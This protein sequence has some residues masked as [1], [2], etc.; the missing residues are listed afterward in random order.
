MKRRNNTLLHSND[1]WCSRSFLWTVLAFAVACMSAATV[2][3]QPVVHRVADL[4]PGTN[5]SFPSNLTVFGSALFL[6]AYTTNT[7]RELWKYDGGGI[8]LVSNINDTVKDI[9]F[10][11][12][13]GNDSVPTGLKE[14]SGKLYFSAFD[15]RRGGE[16]WRTDGTNAVRVADINP[17]ANDTIKTNPASSWP[18]E[19]TAAGSKLYFSADS[20]G[21]FS[22][23]ELWAYDGTS[24]AR[25]A[26]IH[27]DFGAIYS[28]FPQGLKEFNGALYFMAD[29][30]TNGYEL[31]KQS[32]SGSVLLT[33]INPGGVTSSSF[34]KS[35]TAFNNALYFVATSS[36]A[37][38]ELWKTD[39]TNTSLA[40]DLI[41]GSGS[42]FP[43]YLTVFNGALY[44]RATDATRGYELWKFD[45]TTAT[46]AS[47]I[48]PSGDSFAKNL[49]VF[50]DR[51]YFAATDGVHGWELWQHDG[52]A[53]SLV[54]DLNPSGDSFPEQF[55]VFNDVLYF[56]ATTPATG[57][58]IWRYDGSNISRATDINPSAGS[59]YPQNLTVFDRELCFRATEDGLS[60]WE[61]WTLLDAIVMPVVTI[62]SP[63]DGIVLTAPANFT[64]AAT[65][66]DGTVSQV[67][68]FQGTTSL[69][70][71]TTSPYSVAVSS[72]AAG[73][74]T[75]SAVATDNLGAKGTNSVSIVVN[76]LPNVSITTPTNG[77]S[78]LGPAI[79]TIA[80]SATDAD[81]TI[82]R[83]EFFNGA[84]KLGE[85]TTSPYSFSW[86]SVAAGSYTLTAR[87]IDNLGGS[88]TSAAITI[89]VANNA[90][91]SV[92]ITSPANNSVL[93][94]PA[95]F[96]LAA[97]ASDSDGTVSQVEFFQG[98]TSLAV[99]TTSPYSVAVSSLAAGRYTLSA[100]AT[101]NLGAKATNSV[102]LVVNALP[103][104]A[105]TSPTNGQSFTAP[106]S[107][108]IAATADDADGTITKVE[109]FNGS[110]LL[111]TDTTSPYSFSWNSVAA[112][113]YTLTVRAIDNRGGSNTSAIVSISVADN[114]A[115]TVAIDTPANNAVLTALA[116]FTLA[117]T[118]S[119]SDGTVS[120]VE[121]FQ[122]T[123]SLAVDTTSPYSV[124]VSS[125][126]AGSYTLS[127]VA[128]DNLGA[129][130]TNS[131]SIVVNALPTAAITSPTNGQSFIAPAIITIAAS[132]TDSDGTVAKVEFFNGAA[133]LGEDTTSPYGFS[134]NSVMAGS[135][136]LTVKATDNRGTSTI[137]VPVTVAV[138]NI[139]PLPVALLNP[140]WV[141]NDFV[142]SFTTQSGRAYEVQSTE[143][144]GNGTWQ[145]L[146]V[147]TGTGS[148]ITVT[149]RDS[150]I[151][152]R[153]YR[154]ETK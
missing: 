58:E 118:A 127:A 47:D 153:I 7:G 74:Y 15:A 120:Q 116:S 102:S 136:A 125:P 115:P 111:G 19:L 14:F 5:G 110:T 93:A 144:L 152:Q 45:G 138:S 24:T 38:Y 9:G 84:T 133:K 46:L 91:P 87:A 42:S 88:N 50:Q 94:A 71:D 62:T 82:T 107:I 63:P 128:T 69:A 48:N 132:A 55:T 41:P 75:L 34:P 130:A 149:N 22:N 105:I 51:L 43:E 33:N 79:I 137:S 121:F 150:I 30:G 142:F 90:T 57:Y 36:S 119:D 95:S 4:N 21:L 154:V 113:N 17:D 64:L 16:L 28:S 80:A 83:V 10:G 141:G 2:R 56:V 124:A 104:A 145:A 109:F 52:T 108:T 148:A 31:W 23:Y 12:F 27:P 26:N 54:A 85:D 96:T 8:T 66:S 78:F 146:R 92:A 65:A 101:D 25:A 122:G 11:I 37:G 140:M 3:S 76:A 131:V 98:T 1:R 77:Q 32:A 143:V 126:A 99:D 68:F 44:F 13:I 114:T 129:K 72:L 70:V 100:V 39:G 20:G 73:R 59:S 89:S 134:W 53:A 147:V 97:T 61:L 81:G 18:R 86:S 117:A 6:S 103:T 139:T 106:A 49:A 40:V 123:T 151:T 135:Y 67:E 35:F 60:N 29:D 112:G